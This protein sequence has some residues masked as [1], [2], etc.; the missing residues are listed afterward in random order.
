MLYLFFHPPKNI[1]ETRIN[2]MSSFILLICFATSLFR[3]SHIQNDC[4]HWQHCSH[5][6]PLSY[7]HEAFWHYCFTQFECQQYIA[8]PE[9]CLSKNSC[10]NWSQFWSMARFVKTGY[11][12]HGQTCLE[13][14]WD[15]V[16]AYLN[17]SGYVKWL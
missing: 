2:I 16:G 3:S 1:A 8:C 14:S 7:K 6:S 4:H 10:S 17:I 13:I 11:F 12:L 15:L 9:L 5:N